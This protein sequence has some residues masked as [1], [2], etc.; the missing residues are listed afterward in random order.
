MAIPHQLHAFDYVNQGYERVR[1]A[2][3][4]DPLVLFQRATAATTRTSEPADAELRAKA[5][6]FELGAQIDIE[7]GA[8]EETISAAG[9]KTTKIGIAWKATRRP[10]MFPTLRGELLIYPLTATETQLELAGTYDPPFGV[11]GE[12]L[13]A[14]GMHRLA[15]E[16]V[17]G[18]IQAVAAYLRGAAGTAARA[19]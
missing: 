15:E 9:R 2:V 10:G 8:I 14:A 6:P 1:E 16:T 19:S 13:D 3:L 11:I 18:F 4:K 5:G 12:V 7:I 17:N